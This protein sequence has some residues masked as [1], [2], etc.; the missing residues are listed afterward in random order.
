MPLFNNGHAARIEE[1][2]T[3]ALKALERH[4][5]E[6]TR[7]ADGLEEDL[8]N[9]ETGIRADLQ[10]VVSSL[11]RIESLLKARNGN[12]RA[13]AVV[14]KSAAPIGYATGG[15]GILYLLAEKLLS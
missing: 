10:A 11:G 8:K 13:K 7:R 2:L 9:L 14:K 5:A 6:H 15:G 4:S 3:S 12:G 1:R